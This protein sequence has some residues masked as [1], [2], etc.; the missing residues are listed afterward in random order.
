MAEFLQ[1]KFPVSSMKKRMYI[2]VKKK[3]CFH[4][5]DCMSFKCCELQSVKIKA[6]TK[7]FCVQYL[8]WSFKVCDPFRFVC[9]SAF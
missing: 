2:S 6:F 8:P 9:I 5:A 4:I 1:A 3:T 7:M